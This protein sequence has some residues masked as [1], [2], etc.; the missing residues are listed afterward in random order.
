M[1]KERARPST[2]QSAVKLLPLSHSRGSVLLSVNGFSLLFSPSAL[3]REM[4][5]YFSFFFAGKLVLLRRR[6]GN[7]SSLGCNLHGGWASWRLI[8]MR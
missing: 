6:F 5:N 3:S 8:Q 1:K 7:G 2:Y 4:G